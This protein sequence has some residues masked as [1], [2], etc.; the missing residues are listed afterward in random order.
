MDLI[1]ATVRAGTGVFATAATGG[2]G[3]TSAA[4]GACDEG[5]GVV[6]KQLYDWTGSEAVADWTS[7]LLRLGCCLDGLLE[8][9]WMVWFYYVIWSC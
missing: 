8:G 5:G 2:T 7:W 4:D 3:S 9:G 6:C 1:T